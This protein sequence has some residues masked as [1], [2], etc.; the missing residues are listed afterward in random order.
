MS[1]RS[2]QAGGRV[3]AE[4]ARAGDA[5]QRPLRSRFQARLTPGVGALSFAWRFLWGGSPHR[6]R[7]YHPSIPRVAYVEE[8]QQP[9]TKH[10]KR[11]QGTLE[12]G[13][14]TARPEVWIASRRQEG[15][16]RQFYGGLLR[17]SVE[18]KGT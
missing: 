2:L 11:T 9:R 5:L 16:R 1:R 8:E 10:M 14:V 12:A 15:R 7:S 13:R 3:Q 6:A 17:L 4:R 18:L